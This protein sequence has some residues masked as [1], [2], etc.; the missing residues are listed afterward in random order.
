MRNG[1]STGRA[2]DRGRAS[3]AVAFVVLLAVAAPRHPPSDTERAGNPRAHPARAG[4]RVHGLHGDPR[5]SWD[6]V[7]L[8]VNLT[9]PPAAEPGPYPLIVYLHGWGGSK[10][11]AAVN[12]KGS[13]SA[14]TR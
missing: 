7:P 11:A 4:S 10:D 1:T 6:G 9:F 3:L 8:D 5:S 14:A 13:R 2:E 12:V